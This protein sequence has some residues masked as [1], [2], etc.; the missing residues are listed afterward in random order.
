MKVRSCSH[1]RHVRDNSRRI[2][3]GT[4]KDLCRYITLIGGE[5]QTAVS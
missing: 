4:G 3:A 5:P 1:Y 2:R